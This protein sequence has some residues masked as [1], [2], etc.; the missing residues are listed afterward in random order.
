MVEVT[1]DFFDDNNMNIWN[2]DLIKELEKNIINPER[3]INEKLSDLKKMDEA[4]LEYDTIPTIDDLILYLELWDG[5]CFFS[6]RSLAIARES[7]K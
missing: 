5:Q 2:F 7:K 6:Q 4:M 1:S 3:S